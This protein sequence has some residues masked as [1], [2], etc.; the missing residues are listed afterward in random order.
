M[1]H[2]GGVGSMVP[3]PH[4]RR[5]A[6]HEEAVVFARWWWNLGSLWLLTAERLRSV[7][8]VHVR[9]RPACLGAMMKAMGPGEG[10]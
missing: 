1:S 8:S 7:F 4:G 2:G 10:V 5:S 3:S 9:I 6:Q